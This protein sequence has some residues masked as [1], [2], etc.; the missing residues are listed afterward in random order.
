MSCSIDISLLFVVFNLLVSFSIAIVRDF[1][2]SLIAFRALMPLVK[3]SKQKILNAPNSIDLRI[4]SSIKSPIL[5]DVGL[6]WR[7]EVFSPSDLSNQN[8]QFVN[9]VALARVDNL[10]FEKVLISNGVKGF[11]QNTV[12]VEFGDFVG[13]VLS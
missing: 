2:V 13:G 6:S 12:Y 7:G 11:L 9:K 3:S 4:I 10:D 5:S 8:S 1:W